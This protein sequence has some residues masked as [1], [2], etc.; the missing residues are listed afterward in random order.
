[1]FFLLMQGIDAISEDE[2]R[3]TWVKSS[4]LGWI[5]TSAGNNFSQ[6]IGLGLFLLLLYLSGSQ[7]HQSLKRYLNCSDLMA[8]R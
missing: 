5:E 7:A 2:G 4:V 1:V 6:F 8:R 3:V